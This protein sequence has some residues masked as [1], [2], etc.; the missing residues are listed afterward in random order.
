[1]TPEQLN[2]ALI[3]YETNPTKFIAYIEQIGINGDGL[4]TLISLH[5]NK[6]SRLNRNWQIAYTL[7]FKLLRLYRKQIITKE[8]FLAPLEIFD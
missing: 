1:M 7:Y 2:A 6:R 4:T 8:E 3:E 5:R